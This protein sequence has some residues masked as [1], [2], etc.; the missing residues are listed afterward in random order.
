MS[1]MLNEIFYSIQGEST[2]A[3]LPFVFIRLSGCNLRCRYCDTRYAYDE[4]SP[5]E[6]EAVVKQVA[7]FQCRRITVTGGE[8]LLQEKT[9]ALVTRLIDQGYRVTLETNGSL[10]IGRVE[11]RCIKVMDIKS[12]SS[13]M[14]AHNRW[15]NLELLSRQDEVKFV[16]ADRD[17]FEFACEK[18]ALLGKRIPAGH[19]LFSPAHGVLPP[20]QLARWMLEVRV[21]AR[22]QIQLHKYIWPQVSRGV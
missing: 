20:E 8:P 15:A 19:T 7:R 10:D 13:G 1:L 5:W 4:G 17:D 18:T 16:L 6:L 11:E 14:Q 21:A 3:G 12:P 9:P 2:W 22:L